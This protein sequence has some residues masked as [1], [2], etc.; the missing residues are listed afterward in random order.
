MPSMQIPSAASDAARHHKQPVLAPVT[1]AAAAVDAARGTKSSFCTYLYTLQLALL[2][3][4]KYDEACRSSVGTIEVRLIVLDLES[5]CN[6]APH[7]SD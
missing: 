1:D 2:Y 3:P 5:D 6:I 7:Y 4:L